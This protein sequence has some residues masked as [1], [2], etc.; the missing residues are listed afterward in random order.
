MSTVNDFVH[1]Y[2]VALLFGEMDM[3]REDENDDS[4]LQDNGY[5][6]HD[7]SAKAAKALTHEAVEFYWRNRR[8][9]RAAYALQPPCEYGDNAYTPE[10]AGHDFYFNQAGHGVG[11]WSRDLGDIGDALSEACG[12]REFCCWVNEHNRVEVE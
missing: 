6:V 8:T 10:R 9:L 5:S 1:G 7:F 4:S 2:M 3:D 11:Y 12:R